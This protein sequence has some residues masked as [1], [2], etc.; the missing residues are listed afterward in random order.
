MCESLFLRIKH[1]SILFHLSNWKSNSYLV[2]SIF[3]N[4]IN[5]NRLII[6]YGEQNYLVHQAVS[7]S[8][9][10]IYFLNPKGG[11]I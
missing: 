11:A 2:H 3:K 4:L 8:F 9:Y 1:R 10:G 7:M 5:F 6:D